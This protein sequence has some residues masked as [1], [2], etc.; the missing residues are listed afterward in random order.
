M[1]D[2]SHQTP[3]GTH[4]STPLEQAKIYSMK[5]E[6]QSGKGRWGKTPLEVETT[7]DCSG[8]VNRLCLSS[9]EGTPVGELCA[10]KCIGAHTGIHSYAH[11]A[12]RVSLAILSVVTHINTVLSAFITSN[13][14]PAFLLFQ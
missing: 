4:N 8:C 6:F 3:L 9:P 1:C 13:P 7:S 12:I 14:E 11:G 2:Q 10:C 5:G